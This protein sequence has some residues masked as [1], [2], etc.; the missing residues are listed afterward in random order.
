MQDTYCPSGP[1]QAIIL[2]TTYKYNPCNCISGTYSSFVLSI[3]IMY[4]TGF[5]AC[6][7]EHLSLIRVHTYLPNRGR[8]HPGW[9][10]SW[11]MG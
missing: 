2:A 3:I 4:I 10:R 11:R 8:Q 6:I 9:Q 1:T 5:F 7:E